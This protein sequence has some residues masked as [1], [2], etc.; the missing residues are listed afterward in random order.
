MKNT[1]LLHRNIT[2]DLKKLEEIVKKYSTISLV[3][4]CF[5]YNF[6]RANA[7][8]EEILH[9]PAKQ[10]SFLIGV[11]VSTPEPKDPEELD[12]KKWENILN[13]LNK[14]FNHYWLLYFPENVVYPRYGHNIIFFGPKR[15]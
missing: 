11:V 10:L 3:V 5:V 14:L 13:V 2:E 8:Q 1:E 12:Q 7:N 6:T 4:W 9:S 15:N